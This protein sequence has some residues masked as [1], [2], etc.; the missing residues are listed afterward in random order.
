MERFHE[1][2]LLLPPPPGMNSALDVA[3]QVSLA[4]QT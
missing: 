2:L 4:L 1:A 3:V